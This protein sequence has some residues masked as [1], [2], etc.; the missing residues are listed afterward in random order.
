MP[1]PWASGAT[2]C[3]CGR[4]SEDRRDLEQYLRRG[5]L[6]REFAEKCVP[7][8]FVRSEARE[9]RRELLDAFFLSPP[10]AIGARIWE[11]IASGFIWMHLA[12]TLL[13]AL[14]AFVLGAV[15]GVVVY[16]VLRKAITSFRD[17]RRERM[18]ARTNGYEV[19]S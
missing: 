12:T 4:G 18:E 3:W 11:W 7:R 9:V 15:F 10:S 1:A 6:G 17:R 5:L 13:E 14:L 8:D 2:S 19:Q 16:F